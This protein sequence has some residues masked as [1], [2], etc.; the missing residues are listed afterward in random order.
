MMVR[1]VVVTGCHGTMKRRTFDDTF[2]KED[3][4]GRTTSS[5][6]TQAG[7]D[8]RLGLNPRRMSVL[9]NERVGM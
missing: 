1:V 3:D 7:N 6:P 8:Y 2:K 4:V 9:S 5:S